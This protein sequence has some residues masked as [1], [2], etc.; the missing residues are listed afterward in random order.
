[1][2][3]WTSGKM[4]L[5]IEADLP[6]AAGG[7]TTR[8]TKYLPLYNNVEVVVSQAYE[9]IHGAGPGE[10]NAGSSKKIPQYSFTIDVY[11]I[12]GNLSNAQITSTARLLRSL[13]H[14]RRSFKL[15]IAERKMV[16]SV[17]VAVANGEEGFQLYVEEYDKCY[18]TT[19]DVRHET[20]RAPIATFECVAYRYKP[21]Y[22]VSNENNIIE[23]TLLETQIGDGEL[24]ALKTDET[25]IQNLTHLF[26]WN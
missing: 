13:M 10:W 15:T 1:M 23:H 20:E 26:Q 5:M 2:A 3:D 6:S 18:V 11:A 7:I 9:R 17:I 8:I 4:A 22:V 16:E 21:S 12:E 14:G 19:D 25:S 24:Q